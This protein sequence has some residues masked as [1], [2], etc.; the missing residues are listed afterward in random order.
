MSCPKNR[1][2]RDNVNI[3]SSTV[4][5]VVNLYLGK[6]QLDHYEVFHWVSDLV[7]KSPRQLIN[8]SSKLYLQSTNME[9]FCLISLDEWFSC[10][11]SSWFYKHGYLME[12]FQNYFVFVLDVSRRW[13]NNHWS[14]SKRLDIFVFFTWNFQVGSFFQMQCVRFDFRCWGFNCVVAKLTIFYYRSGDFI[15]S[16]NKLSKT[17]AKIW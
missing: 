11:D 2:Q 6:H 15:L 7:V 9:I 1:R 8:F 14:S 17:G 4:P 5:D 12:K 16:L 10:K 13:W 3:T